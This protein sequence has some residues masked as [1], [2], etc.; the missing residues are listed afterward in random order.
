[1]NAVGLPSTFF[2]APPQ[3]RWL[4]VGYFFIGGLAGGCYFLAALIDFFGR[5]VDRPL[6]RLGY[7]VAFP[8]VVLSGLLLIVD[9]RRPD[10]FWHMLI[11]SDTG[12]PMVKAY[13]PMSLGSWA[14]LLFGA[15][16]FL[17]FLAALEDAGMLRWPRLAIFRPP[18]IAGWVIG[19]LGGILAFFVAGYTGVLLAVTNRP[20]WSDTTLLGLNFLIS[21]ASTSAALIILLAHRRWYWRSSVAT[22]ER[23]DAMV[24]V[25]EFI[26]LVGLIASL[27]SLARVWL[28]AWGALLLLG[29]FA[30]GIVIPLVL[31]WRPHLLGERWSAPAAAVLVLVGGFLLRV[32]VVLSSESARIAG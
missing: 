10:R 16:A 19:I 25:L 27:G 13:S 7:L 4:I 9:L 20:I 17:S 5:A 11:Q 2:T 6:A 22:L 28:N 21:A 3:W 30:V 18:H 32:V 12:R 23:F 8:A 14:L 31:Q 24:L 15:F 26:A 29:V 1:L